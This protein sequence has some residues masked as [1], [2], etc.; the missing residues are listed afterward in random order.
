MGLIGNKRSSSDKKTTVQLLTLAPSPWSINKVMKEFNVTPYQVKKA[1]KLFQ[2]K[3]LLAILPQHKGKKLPP[4]VAQLVRVFENDEFSCLIPG[5]KDYVSIG[6]NV[7]MQKRL[8]LCNLKK[9]YLALKEKH[10]NVKIGFSKFCSLRPKWC[11]N[12]RASSTHS[13]C[14]CVIHQNTKLTIDALN[15]QETNILFL[16]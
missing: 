16:T 1:R 11:V 5:K 10:P 12:V 7:H 13:V 4:E 9:L 6:K 14:V 8:T 2:E 3:E 15:I